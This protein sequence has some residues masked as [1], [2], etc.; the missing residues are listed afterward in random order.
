[1]S[2][3]EI[4]PTLAISMEAEQLRA[5]GSQLADF[6]AGE[7]FFAT[8]E[9]IKNAAKA[10]LDA[11]FTKYT[12]VSG[13]AELRDAIR[14]RHREDFGSDY[15]RDEVIATSGGKLALFE[16]FQALIDHGDEVVIPTP[17]WVSFKDIVQYAGGVPVFVEARREDGYNVSAAMIE[18]AFTPRTK[19]LLLNSPNN[20]S[21]A[22]IPKA[23][24][25]AIVRL[26][27]E[28]GI[29]VVSDEC[30]AYL[31]YTGDD[32]SVGSMLDLKER[33][34]I[35][36]SLSKT[37]AMTGWRLG[38]AM[39]PAPMVKQMQKFQSQ[40]TSNPTS[41]VQKAAIAALTGPQDCVRQMRAEYQRLGKRMADAL[42]QIEGLCCNTP[43]GAFYLYPDVTAYFGRGG[44]QSAADIARRLLHEAHVV[45]VPAE[46]FGTKNEIRL[47][48]A[49]SQE[50]ID[51]GMERMQKF[52][53]EL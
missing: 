37:Y 21:G 32:F 29:W 19:V 27:V 25:Q 20:P 35:V 45:V 40:S 2:R 10:A 9:H 4:S 22:V 7:P 28:R 33:L 49:A 31:D 43:N 44:I 38:Y 14:N 13:I 48:Y 26:A 52:F 47:S 18:A 46:A 16:A 12:V 15:Q 41:F 34:I 30:Y 39:A 36:G 42:N 53:R 11:N 1:M 3:I 6:G 8:P 50:T 23:E 51:I 17:Y 24:L 5:K